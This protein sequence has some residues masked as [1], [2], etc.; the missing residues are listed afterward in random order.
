MLELDQPARLDALRVQLM[1]LAQF[2]LPARLRGKLDASDIVQQTMLNAHSRRKQFQGSTEAELASWLRRILANT[3]IDANRS[4]SGKRDVALE[5][6]LQAVVSQP[7]SNGAAI[8]LVS[9]QSTPSAGAVRN[10]E[11]RQL[12]D[13]LRHLPE[14]QRTAV[15]LHHLHGLPVGEV[16]RRMQRTDTSIAGLLRRGLKALR[17]LLQ[18]QEES[19]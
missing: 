11:E 4:F 1:R 13:A 15:D 6:S 10:E 9:D 7:P 18:S 8:A 5:R 19:S 14:D 2:H 3:I 12:I 16:A 17:S